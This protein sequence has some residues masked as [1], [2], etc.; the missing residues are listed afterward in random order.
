MAA[1]NFSAARQPDEREA[2]LH[3][4][5]ARIGAGDE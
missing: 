3:R 5:L 2:E 4:L 1:V